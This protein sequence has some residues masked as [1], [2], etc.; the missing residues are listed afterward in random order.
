MTMF[1]YQCQETAGNTG[2]TK[3][4]VCG[5]Q[6]QTAG[7]Q[8]VLVYALKGLASVAAARAS[9]GVVEPREPISTDR[10]RI[11]SSQRSTTAFDSA[12]LPT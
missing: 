2:C 4:G 3:R 8:D 10:A 11:C 6:A 12:I 1:C 7:L 5:K 9:A